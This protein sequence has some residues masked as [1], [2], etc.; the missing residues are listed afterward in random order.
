[1]GRTNVSSV[2]KEEK[3]TAN[4]KSR[5]TNF[6][7]IDGSFNGYSEPMFPEE[8]PDLDS[9]FGAHTKKSVPVAEDTSMVRYRSLPLKENGRYAVWVFVI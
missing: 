5:E 1:M 3:K 9:F 8:A 7:D 6:I 4:Q 2:K